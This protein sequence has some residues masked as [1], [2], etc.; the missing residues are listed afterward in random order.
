MKTGPQ[1]FQKLKK[2]EVDFTYLYYLLQ[3]APS[4]S[5]SQFGVDHVFLLNRAD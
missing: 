2:T 4:S 5:R 1:T 3:K